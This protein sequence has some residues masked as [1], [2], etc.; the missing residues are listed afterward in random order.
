[1]AKAKQ[2]ACDEPA[3]DPQGWLTRVLKVRFEEV[4]DYCSAALEADDIKGVHNM[5]VA[6]RRVRSVLRDF[7]DIFGKLEQKR[8][9]KELK[10]LADALGEVR[11]QDVAIG[12]LEEFAAEAEG[13]EVKTGITNLIDERRKLRR[14]AYRAFS[15]KYSPKSIEEMRDR[16]A[17]AIDD[18]NGEP[19]LFRPA[20]A[21]AAAREIITAR[22]TEL[23]ELGR[24]IYDRDDNKA[25][26]KIRI[27][28]K[29]L[30]YAIELFT[31]CLGDK[32]VPF[33]K[34]VAKLQ[35]YLGEVHD[36]DVWIESL[37][38]RSK[39]GD[40]HEATAWLI[41]E[42]EKKRSEAYRSVAALWD[43]WK[44]TD[45]AEGLNEALSQAIKHE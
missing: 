18:T 5:R 42:F 26:H 32:M 14:D 2:I 11:D 29:R 3:A 36:C 21:E 28:A 39:K 9:R 17:R 13:D 35:G 41:A 15:K 16:F 33:A 22:L 40:E 7:E 30:R 6:S 44:A 24:S 31:A 45:F 43:E 10:R 38:E 8:V 25:L 23:S 4:A 1:M 20:T 37:S 27:A 34:E 19:D 12:A